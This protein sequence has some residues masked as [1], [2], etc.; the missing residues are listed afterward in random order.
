VVDI[1]D[2]LRTARP[3]KPPLT[4][5]QTALTMRDEA[6]AGLWDQEL[7]A[8]FFQMLDKRRQVA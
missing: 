8:E 6:R 4:H 5:E 2:A 3:Y 1:Y 7:V